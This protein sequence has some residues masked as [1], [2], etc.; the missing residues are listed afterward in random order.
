MEPKRNQNAL[1]RQG[2]FF[3]PGVGSGGAL[4]LS[5]LLP[6]PRGCSFRNINVNAIIAKESPA[7]NSRAGILITSHKNQSLLLVVFLTVNAAG[8]TRR[9]ASACPFWICA[10]SS[11]TDF[12]TIIVLELPAVVSATGS[13]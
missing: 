12:C 13:R 3:Y 6:L 11:S 4:R 9:A 2:V 7:V 8:K 1:L 10:I 5:C